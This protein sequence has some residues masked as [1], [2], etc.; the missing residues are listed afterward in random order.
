MLYNKELYSAN[1]KQKMTTNA[2]K[3]YVSQ[4]T[5][6]NI[7]KILLSDERFI[8][9]V[10]DTEKLY[11]VRLNLKYKK[12]KLFQSKSKCIITGRQRAKIRFLG[13]ISRFQLKEMVCEGQFLIGISRFGW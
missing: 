7:V 11:Q 10:I 12:K 8:N 5:N 1:K 6:S 13:N 2:F 3:S 9:T 4:I